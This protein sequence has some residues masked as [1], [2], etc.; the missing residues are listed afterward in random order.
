MN[1]PNF[2]SENSLSQVGNFI[3]NNYGNDYHSQT[4]YKTKSANAQEAHEA[5]RPT[6][7]SRTPESIRNVLSEDQY[8]LYDLIWKRTVASQMAESQNKK[9]V[10]ITSSE[11]EKYKFMSEYDELV[12]RFKKL[13]LKKNQ[14]RYQYD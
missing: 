14:I 3:Q 1:I 10:I 9:T 13:F 6:S 12:L 7:I 2:L 11:N 4:K 8:K 5:I